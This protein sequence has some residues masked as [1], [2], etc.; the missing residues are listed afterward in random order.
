MSSSSRPA[1]I[2]TW[3]T[4]FSKTEAST[5]PVWVGISGRVG[6]SSTGRVWRLNR[7]DPQIS[8][9]WV[10]SETISTGLLGRE[11]AISFSSRP[12][13]STVPSSVTSAGMVTWA[14]VV[15]SKLESVTSSPEAFISNP[16][17]IG[18]VGRFGKLRATQATA[19]ASASR[20]TRIFTSSP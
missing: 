3:L 16:A 7:A 20:S 17:R 15:E 9:T 2:T 6:Y 12:E 11:R 5:R 14:E 8:S 13:T 4:D 10:W 1:A 19:S 18:A